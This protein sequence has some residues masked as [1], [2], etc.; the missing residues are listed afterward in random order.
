VTLNS[1][2]T[3]NLTRTRVHD[4][5]GIVFDARDLGTR[6]VTSDLEVSN[7]LGRTEANENIFQ[8]VVFGIDQEATASVARARISDAPGPVVAIGIRWA[9]GQAWIRDLDVES[10]AGTAIMAGV[11]GSP[12]GPA[13]GFDVGRARIAGTIDQGISLQATASATISDLDLSGTKGILARGPD[14]GTGLVVLD[15]AR[16]RLSRFLVHDNDR[17][18]ILVDES[19]SPGAG[20]KIQFF[21]GEVRGNAIGVRLKNQTTDAR[22]MFER[23]KVDQNQQNLDAQ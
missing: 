13:I 15:L 23:V 7:V 20:Q 18:G 17:D 14:S 6:L 21:D 22:S 2:A 12:D 4:V 11:S 10:I 16:L 3:T 1:G 9:G 8:G 19:G 5:V